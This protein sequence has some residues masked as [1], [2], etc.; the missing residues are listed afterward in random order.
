MGE[1]RNIE[2]KSTYSTITVSWESQ[3][4]QWYSVRASNLQG[5]QSAV[6]FSDRGGRTEALITRL[7]PDTEY[8]VSGSI[9]L[10]ESPTVAFSRAVRTKPAPP[11]WRSPTIGPTNL[12]VSQTDRSITATWDP[13]YEGATMLYRV[14]LN[15]PETGR[16][17]GP[18]RVI[19]ET[20]FTYHGLQP[21]TRYEVEI[22]HLGTVI[23]SA[24]RTV[25]TKALAQSV[26]GAG[27][28]SVAGLPPFAA[29]T[30]S[31]SWPIMPGATN[32]M[33]ADPWIW[34]GPDLGTRYHVGLDI[35]EHHKGAAL[36]PLAATA[37]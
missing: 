11:G 33:T 16:R 28:S 30:P 19:D 5:S 26:A 34:R 18:P 37:R 29:R 6:Q 3:G 21:S 17:I 9:D 36:G 22:V 35:G 4:N 15:D 2:V 8:N 31:F 27:Q 23:R 12:Q 7:W 10:G 20:S 1:F 32:P 24:K 14:E 25:T 13:P